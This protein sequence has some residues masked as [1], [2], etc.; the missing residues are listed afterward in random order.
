MNH[1][2]ERSPTRIASRTPL[3]V[4]KWP[5]SKA[6][7][8]ASV[9]TARRSPAR[10]PQCQQQRSPV[11]LSVHDSVLQIHACYRSAPS[12][13]TAGRDRTASPCGSTEERPKVDKTLGLTS[14]IYT[15]LG[16]ATQLAT[17]LVTPPV[18][19][20][21]SRRRE[22]PVGSVCIASWTHDRTPPRTTDAVSTPL[23]R[24]IEYAVEATGLLVNSYEHRQF[25]TVAHCRT[26]A[27]V[28]SSRPLPSVDGS[29]L[30]RKAD[31]ARCAAGP[32]NSPI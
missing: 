6:L 2:Y 26:R 11:A 20:K 15:R 29:W 7:E 32:S 12:E 18:P 1:C 5:G 14:V 31:R 3:Y 16:A 24:G 9:L 28:A 22:P 30:R 23:A 10:H 17:P 8:T 21:F 27:D 4:E 13:G 19:A 25:R